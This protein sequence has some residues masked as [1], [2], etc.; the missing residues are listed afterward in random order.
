MPILTKLHLVLVFCIFNQQGYVAFATMQNS[1]F[2]WRLLIKS[3]DYSTNYGFLKR[4]ISA[5]D[6]VSDAFQWQT[7]QKQESP[8]GDF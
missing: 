6:V 4:I 3:E 8:K 2:C 7:R 5:D 1:L